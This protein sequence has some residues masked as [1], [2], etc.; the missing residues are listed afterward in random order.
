MKQRGIDVIL[1]LTEETLDRNYAERIGI[2]VLD[3]PMVNMEG[4]TAQALDEAVDLMGD[5]KGVKVLVHCLA[6]M[7]RTGMVLC[8]YLI[9]VKGM[10]ADDAIKEV[11]RLRPGSLKRRVQI[12]AVREYEAYLL[13]VRSGQP[14]A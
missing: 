10:N 3:L 9:K 2:K 1:N 8:A 13:K 12:R 4:A 6:G 7:G 11:K 14:S 5:G